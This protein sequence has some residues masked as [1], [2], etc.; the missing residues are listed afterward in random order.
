MSKSYGE[1][2]PL[3]GTDAEI[4]KAIMGIV[5]D[6]KRPK[7]KFAEENNIYKI[8]SSSPHQKKKRR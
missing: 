3:F 5:T 7:K 4:E 8:Y 6:P 1:M 2:I